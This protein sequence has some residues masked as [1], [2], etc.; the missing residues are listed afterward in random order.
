MLLQD[1][2]ST[3]GILKRRNMEVQSY[4]CVL[5]HLVTE[6]SLM[7]LFFSCP[8]SMCCWNTLGLA[9]LIPDD[10]F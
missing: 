1:R 8:F 7:Y 4:D 10:L 9:P 2:L 5:C 6:E 3:R